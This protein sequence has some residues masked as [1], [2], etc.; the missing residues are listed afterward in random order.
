MIGVRADVEGSC[1]GTGGWFRATRVSVTY[2][3][4]FHAP[5]E[6]TINIDFM[7]DQGGLGARISAELTPESAR[8]LVAAIE[9]VLARA[10]AAG[11]LERDEPELS[12]VGVSQRS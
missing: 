5:Q 8:R 7:D 11:H 3:H 9:A 4:P 12:L 6:N 10:E 1:K 2:D